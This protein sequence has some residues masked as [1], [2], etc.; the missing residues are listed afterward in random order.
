[1]PVLFELDIPLVN[2]CVES[3]L[4]AFENLAGLFD[5]DVL[6]GMWFR[7]LFN[8]ILY[9]GRDNRFEDVTEEF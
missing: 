1:M 4:T 2:V 7:V 5:F 3:G 6:I 9:C 8:G